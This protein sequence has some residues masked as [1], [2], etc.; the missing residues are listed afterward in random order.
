MYR[1]L[2]G[3]DFQINFMFIFRLICIQLGN[4]FML[5]LQFQIAFL[6]LLPDSHIG[7]LS[8]D[9][10]GKRMLK[11]SC[12]VA[13]E[14]FKREKNFNHLPLAIKTILII[15]YEHTFSAYLAIKLIQSIPNTG[16]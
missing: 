6:L 1:N 10:T 4:F 8:E 9:A 5:F 7:E 11:F 15:G 13:G 12:W 3:K 2:E 16:W 14:S